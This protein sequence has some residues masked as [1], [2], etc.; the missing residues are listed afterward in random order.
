[1]SDKPELVIVGCSLNL[2]VI[3]DLVASTEHM[4]AETSAGVE[5][6]GSIPGAIWAGRRRG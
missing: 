4:P 6:S 3:R 5:L 2:G 1:M